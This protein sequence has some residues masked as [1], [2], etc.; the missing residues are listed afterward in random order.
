MQ[1]KGIQKGISNELSQEE[2]SINDKMKLNREK[3]NSSDEYN[4]CT[5]HDEWSLLGAQIFSYTSLMEQII[6]SQPS[7]S[8]V[9]QEISTESNFVAT[10]R[11]FQNSMILTTS[12]T[13]DIPFDMDY[14]NTNQVQN[15]ADNSTEIGN[16]ATT[17]VDT[18]ESNDSDA[19][20]EML[21]EEDINNFLE[22]EQ[23][24]ATK[25]NNA[26]IDAKYIPRV[27]MQF[28]SIKEAHDFF[29]FYALLAGFSV[30]IAHNYHSTSKKRNGE[31]I[32][33]TFKCNRHGKGKVRITGGGNRRD[34]SSREKQ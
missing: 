32:R 21:T 14:A 28:K 30:V 24:E 26:A 15:S 3:T 33:V 18:V 1:I 22:Q 29:N 7:I 13:E 4:N 19:N 6:S 25:G 23:E 16:Q 11:A 31:V 2:I 10:P 20:G 8:E 17:N 34:S 5:L 9:Q 27:D 12:R